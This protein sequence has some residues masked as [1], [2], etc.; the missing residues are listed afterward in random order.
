MVTQ[1]QPAATQ[2]SPYAQEFQPLSI[3]PLPARWR[4]RAPAPGIDVLG[5]VVTEGAQEPSLPGYVELQLQPSLTPQ[6]LAIHGPS[7]GGTSSGGPATVESFFIGESMTSRT[8]TQMASSEPT[9]R[10]LPALPEVR[11]GKVDIGLEVPEVPMVPTGGAAAEDSTVARTLVTDQVSRVLGAHAVPLTSDHLLSMQSNRIFRPRCS[12]FL[13]L[14]Q[15]VSRSS[16]SFC[17]RI[18]FW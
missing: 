8:S 7:C 6:G 9:P 1:P 16:A 5:A 3:S 10:P 17:P 4:K 18:S 11:N 15:E 14:D 2:L 13:V 12:R